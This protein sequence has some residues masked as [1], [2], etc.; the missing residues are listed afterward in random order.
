MGTGRSSENDNIEELIAQSNNTL[1]EE[2]VYRIMMKSSCKVNSVNLREL[3][4]LYKRFVDLDISKRVSSRQ[5]L[6]TH[7]QFLGLD[8]LRHSPFLRRIPSAIPFKDEEFIKTASVARGTGFLDPAVVPQKDNARLNTG[9]PHQVAPEPQ[10]V[11]P[12]DTA[13]VDMIPYIDFEQFCVYLT[14][15]C[16]RCPIDVKVN[17]RPYSVLFRLFDV[18]GDGQV[19]KQDLFGALQMLIGHIMSSPEIEEVVKSVF[20][21]VDGAEKGHI[22]KD[23][24]AKVMWLT[25]F[26]IKTSIDFTLKKS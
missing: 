22:D 25:D 20:E 14:A 23:D 8:E 7:S 6:L 1:T 10:L 3:Q 24:F 17:C 19:S 9:R 26:D 16:P 13:H 21:E 11:V 15:F 2:T 18:D 4:C 12:T 5:G